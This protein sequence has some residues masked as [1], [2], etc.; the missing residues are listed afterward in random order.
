M[1][2]TTACRTDAG[3]T[4]AT[5]RKGERSVSLESRRL[6]CETPVVGNFLGGT[7]NATQPLQPPEGVRCAAWQP[8]EGEHS[9][10]WQPPKA[11]VAQPGNHLRNN[12]R[13]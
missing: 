6:A 9:E 4:P 1:K 5:K 13:R 2:F 7:A 3:E 12:Q 8:P 10:A 11:Y